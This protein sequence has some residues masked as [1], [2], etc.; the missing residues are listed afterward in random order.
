[1][2]APGQTEHAAQP[3]VFFK[4]RSK[5]K[6][7]KKSVKPLSSSSSSASDSDCIS[8]GETEKKV[9]RQKRNT[10]AIK[11]SVSTKL[12]SVDEFQPDKFIADRTTTIKS[13]NDA[14]RSSNWHDEEVK[15]A[16][17]DK[18]RSGSMSAK[19][20]S[21]QEGN[22][23]GLAN[24]SNFIVE[25]PN[26][27]KRIVGPFRA[28]TNLRTITVTDFAPDVCKDYKQTGFCGFGDSCKYLHAREDYKHGWQLDKE[29]ENITK[30]RRITGGTKI[31]SADRK[32]LDDESEDD[33]VKLENVPFACIICKGN[34][35][36]PII[37]KCRHYFCEKCALKRYKKCQSCAA[38]GAATGG[39]FNVAK[40][41]KRILD[42]KKKKVL[43]SEEESQ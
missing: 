33:D 9:K 11:T 15:G 7:S 42:Q 32:D 12:N 1:M 21:H 2:N 4:K 26:A 37:T 39:V 30:G 29:W 36:D 38:C 28:P 34:Y 10:G 41:L 43:N 3:V 27:P 23:K 16:L 8:D 5:S 25:N 14:T 40:G 13:T 31:S 24:T 19:P 6:Y 35:Q 22:Y 17:P 20:P 18:E